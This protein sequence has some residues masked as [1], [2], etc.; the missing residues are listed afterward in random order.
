MATPITN[1]MAASLALAATRA[2]TPVYIQGTTLTALRVRGLVE[3]P[4]GH[5]YTAN[6]TPL[7]VGTL[8]EFLGC[9]PDQLLEA[10]QLYR[11]HLTRPCATPHLTGCRPPGRRLYGWRHRC[12][13]DRLGDPTAP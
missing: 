4:E 5:P 10:A 7:G 11:W 8:A 6:L 9:R 3:W 13:I 12:G 1:N 2:D